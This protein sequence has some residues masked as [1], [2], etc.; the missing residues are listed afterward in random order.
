MASYL[1]LDD[2]GSLKA[3]IDEKAHDLFKAMPG[4][5]QLQVYRLFK[6]RFGEGKGKEATNFVRNQ[7][8]GNVSQIQALEHV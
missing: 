6:A 5:S 7:D 8:V 1:N 3:K 2:V 4:K